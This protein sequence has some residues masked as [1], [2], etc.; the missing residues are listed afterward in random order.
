MRLP[1]FDGHN[2]FL[3]KI[4]RQPERRAALWAGDGTTQISRAQMQAGGMVGGMFAV[5]IPSPTPHDDPALEA[6]MENPPFVMPLDEPVELAHSQAVALAMIGHLKALERT[7]ELSI[8]TDTAAIRAA[9]A[10]GRTAAVLH[11]EGA[12]PID[13]DLD[14]L[15]LFHDMG[16]RSLGP[17]WSRPTAFGH[18]VPFA[19]PSSP[20]TGPGLTEAGQR[21]IRACNALGIAIDLSHLNEAGFW[22]VARISDAPLIAT[23]SNAH[24][25][26]PSS[27]NLTD[28]QLA[29]IRDSGG[30]VGLNFAAA[31]L[32][33]EGRRRAFAGWD[34]VLRHLDHLIGILGEDHVGLG[35]DF[36]GALTPEN[37][38]DAAAL[39]ALWQALAD[40]G[41]GADLLRKLA[42]DN[43]LAA[44]DRS[45]HPPR[46]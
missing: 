6:A 10:A 2:D 32:D 33:P 1:S 40:H 37:L 15:Y 26:T 42:L 13:P 7:G 14:A 41:Y 21:L 31:F 24:A 4:L 22:D 8:C 3:L 9:I 38:P 35:S 28:R 29:A 19:C 17:V 12:E 27:R 39:P 30:M 11:I 43:W 46:A 34:P 44:L 45:W 25:V 16:L 36:D 20:D 5:Y 18:G 23:H